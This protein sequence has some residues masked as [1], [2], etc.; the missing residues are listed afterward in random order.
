MIWR[1]AR[2]QQSVLSPPPLSSPPPFSPSPPQKRELSNTRILPARNFFYYQ[3][4]VRSKKIAAGGNLQSLLFEFKNNMPVTV[5]ILWK[6][7]NDPGTQL[8]TLWSAL[9]WIPPC[10]VWST[11]VRRWE[12]LVRW[13][14][15]LEGLYH[16]RRSAPLVKLCSPRLPSIVHSSALDRRFSA[17]A[18]KLLSRRKLCLRVRTTLVP[19]AVSTAY[20]CVHRGQWA[21]LDAD[22]FELIGHHVW[23]S[24]LLVEPFC[25]YPCSRKLHP[26]RPALRPGRCS[27][28]YPS[29]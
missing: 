8:A 24:L 27:R 6:M 28:I 23:W 11:F 19:A 22:M 5:V 21:P 2:A 16:K 3:F 29:R 10:H 4:L 15:C 20:G 1:T 18:F 25:S 12:C 7:V 13:S 9:S 17:S 26:A 14:L